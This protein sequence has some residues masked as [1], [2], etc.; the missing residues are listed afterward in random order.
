MSDSAMLAAAA[1]LYLT[2]PE[3]PAS[4][5]VVGLGVT[6]G[7]VSVEVGVADGCGSVDV[8]VAVGPLAGVEAL[9]MIG[10]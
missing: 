3:M 5:G 6:D 8:G 2:L 1:P 7:C 4:P 9:S 10:R